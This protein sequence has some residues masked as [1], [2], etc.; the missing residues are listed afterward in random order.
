[1]IKVFLF[2]STSQESDIVKHLR[3]FGANGNPVSEQFQ[4]FWPGTLQW[5]A[6]FPVGNG[7]VHMDQ[8][9]VQHTASLSN[10]ASIKIC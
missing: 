6:M 8:E 3:C 2:T 1:M 4:P 7:L 5:P 10:Q 9:N